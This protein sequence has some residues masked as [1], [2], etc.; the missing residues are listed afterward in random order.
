LDPRW[1]CIATL[2]GHT[3]WI[4]SVSWSPDGKYFAT[5]SWDK[6]AKIWTLDGQCIATLTGHTDYLLSASWSTDGIYFA[7]S[8]Y[9]GVTK[10]WDMH[11][12]NKI[13]Q[14][15]FSYDEILLI[16]AIVDSRKSGLEY[17]LNQHEQ[18]IFDQL[19]SDDQELHNALHNILKPLVNEY[20][21][22]IQFMKIFIHIF[23]KDLL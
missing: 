21:L 8:S 15:P 10:I 4:R 13:T 20:D 5:A 3:D 1:Q 2:I 7:A 18:Q 9:H 22:T 14:Y 11:L 16:K 6:T 12:L 23:N 17:P 19:G